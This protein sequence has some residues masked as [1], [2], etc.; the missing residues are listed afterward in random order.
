ME[1]EPKNDKEI[2]VYADGEPCE[3]AETING[4]ALVN[5]PES[6]SDD[7]KFSVVMVYN[8]IID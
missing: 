1:P 5:P 8:L 3:F 6:K 2:I 4:V 7:G